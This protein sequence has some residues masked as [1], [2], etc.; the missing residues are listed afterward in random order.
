[1]EMAQSLRIAVGLAGALSQ[2]HKR[3]LFMRSAAKCCKEQ[4]PAALV[5]RTCSKALAALGVECEWLLG[6]LWKTVYCK[7]SGFDV[8]C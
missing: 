4:K 3:E 1:M 5:Q 8:D 7:N 2:L 6:M